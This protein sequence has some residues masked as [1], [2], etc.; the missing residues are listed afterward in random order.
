MGTKSRFLNISYVL[1][2]LAIKSRAMILFLSRG[3]YP[4]AYFK[5]KPLQYV[6]SNCSLHFSNNYHS[7]SYLN[8][9]RAQKVH[10]G[11]KSIT[12]ELIIGL[13]LYNDLIKDKNPDLQKLL[14]LASKLK[15]KA[16]YSENGMTF[17][18]KEP[19]SR[20]NLK[21]K[22]YSGIV[23]GKAA[24][25]FLRCFMLTGEDI[26]R[27]WAK[28]CLLSALKPVEQGGVLRKLPNDLF[29]IEEYPSPRPSMVLNGYLFY[30]IALAEYLSFEEDEILK[31]Q[32]QT[33]LN[34]VLTWMPNYKLNKG[35]LYSMYRWNL[36]N[37]H[38]TG[39][40][41]YQFEHL[42]QLTSVPIFKD[43]AKFT[44]ALTNWK[45][46]HKLI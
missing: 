32:F 29:W 23:Q 33:S 14:G 28:K 24:S 22:Y 25:F 9:D 45:A 3:P 21:G 1:H 37:V 6:E 27:E 44:D 46:F 31:T 30:I 17:W 2:S 40:M 7:L 38:Y 42:Y 8:F 18:F 34:S 5:E 19:Y 11:E 39:I 10:A 26:Y 13:V 15:Q 35:L 12:Q 20:F 16:E 4:Y 41:K 43:Y 36:C